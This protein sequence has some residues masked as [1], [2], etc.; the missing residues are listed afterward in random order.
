MHQGQPGSG[1]EDAAE[2]RVSSSPSPLG[3]KVVWEE[4]GVSWR[5]PWAP[6]ELEI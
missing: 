5:A 4:E 2:A 3:T 6:E 1:S